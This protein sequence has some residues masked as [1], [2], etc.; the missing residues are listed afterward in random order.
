ML[1]WTVSREEEESF[2]PILKRVLLACLLFSLI[3]PWLPFRKWIAA[4]GG[5]ARR[6]S[7]SCLLERQPAPPP[8]RGQ[9][10]EPEV[11]AKAQPE[12]AKPEP[13]KPPV[14]EAGAS[15]NRPRRRGNGWRPPAAGPS[16]VGLLAMKDELADLRGA[17]V[18]AQFK[19]DIKPGP[20]VGPVPGRRG[21]RKSPGL[22][23]AL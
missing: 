16:G 6:G 14:A 5:A 12:V 8:A 21:C 7:P 2:R 4:R 15:P 13:K 17:P 9:E 23:R 20:G 3:M 10:T 19:K 22:P 11:A 1:P 18:A